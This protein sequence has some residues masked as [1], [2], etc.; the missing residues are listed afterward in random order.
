LTTCPS[1]KFVSIR[2]R[3]D[4]ASMA[5]EFG[6]G[7]P[8]FSIIN[9]MIF[10]LG[11]RSILSNGSSLVLGC[12]IPLELRRE[13]L[14]G[15]IVIDAQVSGVA[16]SSNPLELETARFPRPLALQLNPFKP[17]WV[18]LCTVAPN[19]KSRAGVDMETDPDDCLDHL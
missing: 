18:V 11:M 2:L 12:R 15:S 16:G 5:Y 13:K 4:L 1:L 9:V 8:G 3:A 19:H 10:F 7:N 17:L 14:F 6:P